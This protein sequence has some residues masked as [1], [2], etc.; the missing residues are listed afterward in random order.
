MNINLFSSR[1]GAKQFNFLK[2]DHQMKTETIGSTLFYV[3]KRIGLVEIA[4]L[5]ATGL[6]CWLIGWR[7]LIEY[8]NSLIWM[9]VA[10]MVVG[11]SSFFGG[12]SLNSKL[13]YQYGKT[14]MPNSMQD[15]AQQNVTDT[16]AS[17]SFTTRAGLAGFITIGVGYLVRLYIISTLIN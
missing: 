10:L 9:G 4:I 16:A 12:A 8:S 11:I 5:T 14:V 6:A 2:G 17:I 15:R 1:H 7:T 3:A 13:G